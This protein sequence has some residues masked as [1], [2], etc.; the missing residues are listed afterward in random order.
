MQL[1]D[2]RKKIQ[3]YFISSNICFSTM[4]LNTLCDA[5]EEPLYHEEKRPLLRFHRKLAP[6]KIS[7]A[8]TSSGKCFSCCVDLVS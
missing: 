8:V 5:Y 2:S 6:Y 1:K 3:P 4:L 7:F